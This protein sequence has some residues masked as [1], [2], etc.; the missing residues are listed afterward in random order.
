MSPLI[1]IL[2]NTFLAQNLGCVGRCGE[3]R[4]V[5]IT[6]GP[7]PV[8]LKFLD[9]HARDKVLNIVLTRWVSTVF[10]KDDLSLEDTLLKIKGDYYMPNQ[11]DRLWPIKETQLGISVCGVYPWDYD[12]KTQKERDQLLEYTVDRWEK[13]IILGQALKRIRELEL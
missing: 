13:L 5:V 6:R 8:R 9:T 7:E 4:I 12:F 3:D 1:K 10:G 2:D 11:V